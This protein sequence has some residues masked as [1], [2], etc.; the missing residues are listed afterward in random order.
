MDW[1]RGGHG[2]S[3]Q[4]T[5]L[6]LGLGQGQ[7]QAAG[8]TSGRGKMSLFEEQQI[9]RHEELFSSLKDELGLKG[10]SSPSSS[11]SSSS[12]SSTSSGR[13]HSSH[14]SKTLPLPGK[15]YTN[16]MVGQFVEYDGSLESDDQSHSHVCNCE[17]PTSMWRRHT[18]S[19]EALRIQNIFL[20][21]PLTNEYFESGIDFLIYQSARKRIHTHFPEVFSM[22]M[23]TSWLFMY[24]HFLNIS[25]SKCWWIRAVKSRLGLEIWKWTSASEDIFWLIF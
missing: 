4:G 13:R 10:D 19:L 16:E 5:G 25:C 1:S 23:S 17:A 22:S 2:Q 6:V 14:L 8:A 18:W 24:E 11:S 3:T 20:T 9:Q 12:S 21:S 7:G 15:T